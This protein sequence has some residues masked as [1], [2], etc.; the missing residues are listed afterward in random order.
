MYGQMDG[1]FLPA[2]TGA[3]PR[4]RGQSAF[5]DAQEQ[6]DVGGCLIYE[7][8]VVLPGPCPCSEPSFRLRFASTGAET[9]FCFVSFSFFIPPHT[10]ATLVVK[11]ADWAVNGHK[12]R[13]VLV[14]VS[15]I[16]TLLPKRL[17]Q[18]S[19]YNAKSWQEK[20]ELV[21]V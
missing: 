20:R 16:M 11:G 19:S 13:H 12:M 7:S 10:T 8:V 18:L 5:D 14:M 15:F 2:A 6:G 4:S 17:L 21:Q 3:S 1:L 9:L